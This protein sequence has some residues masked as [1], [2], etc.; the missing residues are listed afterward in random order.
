MQRVSP[1]QA[2]KHAWSESSLGKLTGTPDL[3]NTSLKVFFLGDYNYVK[4]TV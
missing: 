1:R 3:D 2:Q 4:L